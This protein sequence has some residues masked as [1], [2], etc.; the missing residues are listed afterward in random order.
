MDDI[1]IDTEGILRRAIEPYH[2]NFLFFVFLHLEGTDII[3]QLLQTC[4]SAETRKE[5][6]KLQQVI[7]SFQVSPTEDV[8]EETRQEGNEKEEEKEKEGDADN[9]LDELSFSPSDDPAS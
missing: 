9:Q 1:T 8:T 3:Q 7:D 2:M 6:E 5:A 4:T